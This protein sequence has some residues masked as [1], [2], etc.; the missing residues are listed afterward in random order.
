MFNFFSK[1]KKQAKPEIQEEQDLDIQDLIKLLKQA[2]IKLTS[3]TGGYSGEFTSASE[4]KRELSKEIDEISN[5]NKTDLKNI[6]TWF[7]PTCAWDDFVGMDGQDLGD[8]IH[9]FADKWRKRQ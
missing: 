7:A 2:H 1:N 6:W 4:F 3:Y 5:K 8:K 9:D